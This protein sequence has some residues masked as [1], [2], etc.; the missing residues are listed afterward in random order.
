MCL[1]LPYYGADVGGLQRVA[2]VGGAG[3]VGQHLSRQLLK[4]G[5]RVHIVDIRIPTSFSDGE[6]N[7]CLSFSCE[8]I[9]MSDKIL[10]V[11]QDF[12]PTIVI[13]LAGWGMCGTAMLSKKCEDVN[14]KG[15]TT[16]LDVC[17]QLNV[18]YFIYTSTVNVIFDGQEI[19]NGDES[20]PYLELS[21]YRDEYS[22]SKAIAEQTVLKYNGRKVK[23]DSSELITVCLR[24]C[25]IYGIG[26]ETYFPRIVQNIDY[27][28]MIF[29]IGEALVDWVHV[30]NL[31]MNL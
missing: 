8:N 14:V 5:Y 20:L 12:L 29:Q 26:E 28:F 27:G 15:T 4:C 24:P 13:Q 19:H 18:K 3:Y 1:S 23:N 9:L 17:L 2:I 25:G 7:P 6:L 30:D 11:L 16:L 31:V 10:K 22:K 21:K